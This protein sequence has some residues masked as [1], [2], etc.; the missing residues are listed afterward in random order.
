MLF[1]MGFTHETSLTNLA[2]PSI[3]QF[4]TSP[5][6]PAMA[7][8]TLPKGACPAGLDVEGGKTPLL[9]KLRDHPSCLTRD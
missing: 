7:V 5:L 4:A 9:A 1:L 3:P 6:H 2:F 8:S